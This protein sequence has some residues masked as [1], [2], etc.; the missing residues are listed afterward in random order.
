MTSASPEK[1]RRTG[2]STTLLRRLRR[3]PRFNLSA[4]LFAMLIG[5]FAASGLGPGRSLVLAFVISA[6]VFLAATAHMF[7]QGKP[8]SIRARAREED[9]GHWSTLASSIG[10]SSVVLVALGLELQASKSGGMFGIALAASCLLLSWFFMNTM[11]ALHYAHEYY[12]D[13]AH[14][15][16]RGGLKFPSDHD[17][18]YWDFVYFAFV[19]GMTFQVSDVQVGDRRLRRVALVHGIVAF[20]FNVV[21]VALSVNIVAGKA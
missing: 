10:V 5:A 21:I 20:F 12:G 13:D 8:T 4:L 9:G 7:S 14:K 19:L 17:P 1:T 2:T 3:R 6:L 18:D 11:F 15:R 16:K